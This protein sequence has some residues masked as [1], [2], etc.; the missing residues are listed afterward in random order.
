MGPTNDRGIRHLSLLVNDHTQCDSLWFGAVTHAFLQTVKNIPCMGS[1][2]LINFILEIEKH[3]LCPDSSAR[4]SASIC[5]NRTL[6]AC[7]VVQEALSLCFEREQP[8][9]ATNKNAC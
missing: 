1:H 3:P 2:C 7:M 4:F 8:V 9:R 6:S 5:S